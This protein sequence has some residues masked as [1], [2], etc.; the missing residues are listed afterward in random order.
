MKTNK[1]L[2]TTSKTIGTIGAPNQDSQ[3]IIAKVTFIKQI[4]MQVTTAK[5][6][7]MTI[8]TTR[9]GINLR[10]LEAISRV[11]ILIKVTN[12]TQEINNHN[13]VL[14]V[15]RQNQ[16]KGNQLNKTINNLKGIFM[17]FGRTLQ[18]EGLSTSQLVI[19]N[20]NITILIVLLTNLEKIGSNAE[21]MTRV[22][23][24]TNQIK[25][26]HSIN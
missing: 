23:K 2:K 10:T 9:I 22:T 15:E 20:P 8:K 16:N 19:R 12:N 1:K 6:L 13:R 4:S 17:S 11:K 7:I 25:V 26:V 18:I 24:N 21:L 5:T 3:Q 14:M